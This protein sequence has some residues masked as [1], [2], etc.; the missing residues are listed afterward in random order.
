MKL[1]EWLRVALVPR[2][3]CPAPEPPPP[4]LDDYAVHE[5]ELTC[6]PKPKRGTRALAAFLLAR[7]GGRDV[8]IA[9]SCSAAYSG[10]EEGRAFDW[11]VPYRPNVVDD[12][13]RPAPH[14]KPF[15][16]AAAERLVA[17]L[18]AAGPSGEHELA[19]RLGVMY[20]IYNR[21]IWRSYDRPGIPRG[22]AAYG[23]ASPHVDH[24][25]LSQSWAGARGETSAFREGGL[26]AGFVD[27]A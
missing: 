8:G 22:W 13:G 27:A 9:R 21:R 6:D 12:Q 5:P 10:H 1:L 18:L 16:A 20:L 7:Y 15:D 23:G 19:R 17:E 11:G 2:R 24:V 4:E 14:V 26:A 25:H 3:S